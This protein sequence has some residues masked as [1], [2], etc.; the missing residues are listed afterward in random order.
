[1]KHCKIE[2]KVIEAYS[3]ETLKQVIEVKGVLHTITYLQR[4]CQ[5]TSDLFAVYNNGVR[6]STFA[7]FLK[8]L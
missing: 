5:T 3:D 8:T 6:F 7:K 4:P 2:Y 1:M